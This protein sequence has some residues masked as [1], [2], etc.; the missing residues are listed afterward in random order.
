MKDHTVFKDA[1]RTLNAA[2]V[3]GMRA[4][5]IKKELINLGVDPKQI[6]VLKSKENHKEN[7]VILNQ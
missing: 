7:S 6:N 1:S 5:K 2:Q 4:Q 3:A